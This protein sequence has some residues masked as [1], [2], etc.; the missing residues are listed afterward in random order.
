MGTDTPAGKV[1]P[2]FIENATGGGITYAGGGKPGGE[3]RKMIKYFDIV[4]ILL[5]KV[6]KRVCLYLAYWGEE[7]TLLGDV[8]G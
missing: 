6:T 2:G 3:K 1:K 8:W 4:L 5:Q 7:E